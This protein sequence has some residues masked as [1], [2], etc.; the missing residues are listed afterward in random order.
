MG[1]WPPIA[2]KTDKSKTG[3]ALAGLNLPTSSNIPS[4]TQLS[5]EI[6]HTELFQ[7]DFKFNW[8]IFK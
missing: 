8:Y 2:K 5:E 3:V 1:L 6:F 7:V 4:H